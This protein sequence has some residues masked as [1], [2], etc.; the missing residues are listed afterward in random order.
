M[1]IQLYK[2]SKSTNI[3]IFVIINI[4]IINNNAFRNQGMDSIDT[5]REPHGKKF[6]SDCVSRLQSGLHGANWWQ[7][8]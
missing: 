4:T 3:M 7:V 6:P 1:I 8:E 2:F 5:Q